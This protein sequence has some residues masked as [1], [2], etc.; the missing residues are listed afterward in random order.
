MVVAIVG[1]CRAGKTKL[2]KL[3]LADHTRYGLSVFQSAR[4]YSTST[5]PWGQAIARPLRRFGRRS[6]RGETVPSPSPPKRRRTAGSVG[7]GTSCPSRAG[8][9]CNAG[10]ARWRLLSCSP[11][12]RLKMQRDRCKL[13]PRRAGRP[14]LR[15]VAAEFNNR[16][17][18]TSGAWQGGGAARSSSACCAN[19][20]MGE[21]A[22][23]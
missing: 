9:P 6:A 22:C 20:R 13:V 16:L 12:G 19:L 2:V 4:T 15:R 7:R 3:L 10:I 8:R 11:P 5:S 23:C 1:P 17:K 14:R 21:R 18:L